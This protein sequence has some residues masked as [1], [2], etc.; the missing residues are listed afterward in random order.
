M[1]KH[2]RRFGMSPGEVEQFGQLGMVEPRVEGEPELAGEHLEAATE[3][4]R[5][6]VT[7]GRFHVGVVDLR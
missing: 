1:I 7:L 2:D 6:H 5:A 3:G 4:R